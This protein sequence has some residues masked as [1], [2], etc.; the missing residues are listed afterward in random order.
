MAD[1][2]A[3]KAKSIDALL[4]RHDKKMR[5]LFLKVMN[6]HAGYQ[7][8]A[9]SDNELLADIREAIEESCDDKE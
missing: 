8:S 7:I 5:A 3:T 1:R 9:R 4:D 2:P 6:A